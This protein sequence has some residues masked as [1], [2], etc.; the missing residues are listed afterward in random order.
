MNVHYLLLKSARDLFGKPPQALSQAEMEQVQRLADRQSRIEQKVLASTEAR[1]VAVPAA[2]LETALSEIRGRYAD[3]EAFRAD[4]AGNGLTPSAYATALGRELRA[5]AVLDK[6]GA[7]AARVS[8][9]DAELYYLYHQD[10]FRRPETR[11]A[12]HILVT[13]NPDMADNTRDNAQARIEAIAARLRKDPA[14][15]EEQALKHSECPTAL[16]GGLLGEVPRGTLYPELDAVLFE[17][18]PG[19]ISGVLESPLGLHLLCCEAV[20]PSRLLPIAEVRDGIRQTLEA[21]RRNSCQRAWLKAI[22]Q[23][24]AAELS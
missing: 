23:P 1:N 14:R 10:Q 20:V 17:L 4:L 11:R 2:T 9:I 6:V 3:E 21:R 5:Q 8:D 22:D 18:R 19:E 7:R 24:G 12:R 15:F 16:R 13:I